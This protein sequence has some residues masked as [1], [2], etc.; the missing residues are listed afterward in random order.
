MPFR[1]SINYEAFGN[2]HKIQCFTP[3]IQWIKSALWSQWEWMRFQAVLTLIYSFADNC[4]A[5]GSHSFFCI[6]KACIR[7]GIHAFYNIYVE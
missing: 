5:G 2:V 7:L 1:L 3:L 6:L 4:F